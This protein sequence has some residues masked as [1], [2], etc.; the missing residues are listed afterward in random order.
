M[1][2]GQVVTGTYMGGT[3][4]TVKMEVGGAVRTYE[5]TDIASLQFTAGAPAAANVQIPAGTV[6]TVRL[7]DPMD[8]DAMHGRG[9]GH[10]RRADH[11][12]VR[13]RRDDRGRRMDRL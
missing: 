9:A 2:S 3:A 13:L 1:R 5:V 8:E 12:R 11:R 6:F 7:I 4:R 10:H